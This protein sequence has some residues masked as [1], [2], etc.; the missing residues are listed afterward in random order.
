MAS[1]D[2]SLARHM[3]WAAPALGCPAGAAAQPAAPTH[4]ELGGAKAMEAIG[5]SV[6]GVIPADGPPQ[7]LDILS[8]SDPSL[9][10]AGVALSGTYTNVFVEKAPAQ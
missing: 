10:M 4:I 3:L 1:T 9:R 6:D 8:T 7:V 2:L 5:G